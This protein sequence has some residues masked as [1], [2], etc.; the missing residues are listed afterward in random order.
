MPKR[1]LVKHGV[2]SIFIVIFTTL[3]I[4]VIATSFVRLMIL[5]QQ[6]A[7]NSDLADSAYD[8]ALTGVEDAKR[9]LIKYER[10]ICGKSSSSNCQN[11]TN[12]FLRGQH[13]GAVQGILGGADVNDEVL[14]A[15]NV[16]SNDAKLDQAYTCVKIKYYTDDYTR[17]LDGNS[18]EQIILPL[19]F[20]ADSQ[21]LQL[22][23]HDSSKDQAIG[24]MTSFNVGDKPSWPSSWRTAPVT[25]MVQYIDANSDEMPTLYLRPSSNGDS[26]DFNYDDTD[27]S[28]DKDAPVFPVNCNNTGAYR[29]VVNL[30]LPTT[31]SA[32]DRQK[33]LKVTKIYGNK[34]TIN[35]GFNRSGIA[36]NG[37]Q[38]EIDSTGRANY[39][40]RR[41]KA[42]VEFT[43][44][45]FPVP[46]ASLSIGSDLSK[47]F[48]VTEQRVK[49]NNQ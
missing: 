47:E 15:S 37:I 33:F 18:G 8:S 44:G 22:S 14:I 42:R 41:V 28:S 30:H 27:P 24:S 46:T 19:N 7:I 13:C 11:I 39:I 34:T 32:G 29:C 21:E 31:V 3:L 36:F 38:P 40:V 17:D 49:G 25:L 4:T 43:T 6:R 26:A 23:W 10:E 20:T 35:F 45:N 16:S 12:T 5:D 1:V 9:A 2:V 48:E